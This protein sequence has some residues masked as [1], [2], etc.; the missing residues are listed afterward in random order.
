MEI[1]IVPIGWGWCEDDRVSSE[2]GEA[3]HCPQPIL[4]DDHY[5]L[6]SAVLYIKV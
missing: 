5:Q 4:A 3:K 2:I 6:Y 1:I